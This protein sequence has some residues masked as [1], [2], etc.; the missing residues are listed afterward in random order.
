MFGAVYPW[1]YWPM[2]VMCFILG[3]IGLAVFPGS[4]R[5]PLLRSPA[6]V[7]AVVLTAILVQL[8]PL[9]RPILVSISPA[10]DA[11]LRQYDVVYAASATGLIARSFDP[12]VAGVPTHALSIAPQS[13]LRG[14]AFVA[15]LGVFCLGTARAMARM[16]TRR[17]V[18]GLIG[19]ALVVAL[20]G[21][22]QKATS[23]DKIYGIWPPQESQRPFGPFVNPNH[24]AGW[25]I[26]AMALSIG[27]LSAQISRGMRGVTPDLRHR[28]LWF[29][30]REASLLIMTGAAIAVMGL[31][32]VMTLSRSGIGCFAVAILV[33]GVFVVRRP[34]DGSRR[35]VAG[36][37]L[38]CLLTVTVGW[39]GVDR[40]VQEFANTRGSGLGNRAN[41][42]R[43]TV[44][45]ISD[46]PLTGSGFNTYGTAMLGYQTVDPDHWWWREAHNDY[47]QLMA[48]GGLLLVVPSIAAIGLFVR[49]VRRRFRDGNADDATYW[50]R[51]G[52]L[53][54]I[55][56][57]ALQEVVEFSLQIPGNAVL[58]AVLAAI[59]VHRPPVSKPQVN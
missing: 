36:I 21:I 41:A 44:Q 58:F 30:S 16:G 52:A 22:I 32:L 2:L 23:L 14:L 25:M 17:V 47:L 3:V 20:I 49:E 34:A 35:T 15:A 57:M 50:I 12:G 27:Y 5:T 31:S 54:G 26:M 33:F 1:A 18:R 6:A 24:F 4:S 9:S 19:L 8:V 42:W 10:A 46:F 11:F 48:E 29:S 45:V 51:I 28:V 13:T 40:V 56:A 37:Y 39:A 38:V 59:V 55:I 53:T 7:L 43:D